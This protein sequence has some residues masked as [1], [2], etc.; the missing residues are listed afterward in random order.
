MTRDNFWQDYKIADWTDDEWEALCDGCGKCCLIRLEDE[1]N[2]DIYNTDVH[3]KL[4][5]NSKCQCSDYQNRRDKVPD[6]VKLDRDNIYELS[7]LPNTCAY[8]LIAENKP[9]Y[10]WHYLVN[11]SHELMHSMGYSVREKTISETRVKTKHLP[12]H[13]KHWKGEER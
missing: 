5:D 1:D 12:N 6:C 7:W 9:L 13:I 8:R 4:F 2:G 3:C 10:N 11:G